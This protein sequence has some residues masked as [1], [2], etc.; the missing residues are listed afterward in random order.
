V[1]KWWQQ[2]LGW[3]PADAS[4]DWPVLHGLQF[5][6][7][8]IPAVTAWPNRLDVFMMRRG[9]IRHKWWDGASWRPLVP[10][11]P[12]SPYSVDP[13]DVAEDIT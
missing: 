5:Y 12:Q 6:S 2:G 9:V 7:T 4:D 11:F 3:H 1:H 8:R 10:D 13:A